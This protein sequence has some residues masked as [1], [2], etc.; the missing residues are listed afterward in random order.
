MEIIFFVCLIS[1]KSGEK[2]GQVN[3]LLTNVSKL[4]LDLNWNNFISNE[5]QSRFYKENQYLA[6]RVRK[7]K[8]LH[9]FQRFFW[10][11][12]SNILMIF[13]KIKEYKE[14]SQFAHFFLEILFKDSYSVFK[15]LFYSNLCSFW[16]I[17]WQIF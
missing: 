16:I 6:K 17:S 2:I 15:T 4:T 5:T 1:R 11:L 12:S 8:I 13:F 14:S 10:I 9:V 3:H 7:F